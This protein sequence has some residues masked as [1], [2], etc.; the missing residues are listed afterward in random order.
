MIKKFIF[1]FL[2]I[3]FFMN[4]V[5]AEGQVIDVVKNVQLK[6]SDKLTELGSKIGFD[7]YAVNH[8]QFPVYVSMG[9]ID[10]KNIYE[11]L[12]PGQF[13]IAPGE[14]AYLGW[15]IQEDHS[16]SAQWKLQWGVETPE[17]TTAISSP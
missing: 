8:N 7:Y 17:T 11:G 13:T 14:D 10:Q 5:F 12:V 3:C 1:S 4:L 2:S 9:A 6:T 15:I 16:K